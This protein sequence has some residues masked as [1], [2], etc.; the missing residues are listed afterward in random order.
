MSTRD[1]KYAWGNKPSVD[2]ELASFTVVSTDN[3]VVVSSLVTGNYSRVGLSFTID[4]KTSPF[5][6]RYYLP[7]ILIVLTSFLPFY[8]DAKKAI[9]VAAGALAVLLIFSG[10]VSTMLAPN[11]GV[12]TALDLF[13][14]ASIGTAFVSLLLVVLTV[15][16]AEGDVGENGVGERK[17]ASET[18]NSG[19]LAI[20]L[21]IGRFF[22][23]LVYAITLFLVLL[24]PLLWSS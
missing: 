3:Y 12:T 13:L 14:L 6:S 20:V 1:I 10:I 19:R 9:F 2:V 7:A 11:S 21:K 8:L 22:L 15:Y 5:I 18:L 17:V 4:R 16:L 23:P 24:L